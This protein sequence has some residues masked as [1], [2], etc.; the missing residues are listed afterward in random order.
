[1]VEP[2]A[3]VGGSR[4]LTWMDVILGKRKAREADWSGPSAGMHARL[5]TV[6]GLW[7]VVAAALVKPIALGPGSGS[8]EESAFQC[9]HDRAGAV[10][11]VELGE[12]A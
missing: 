1:M 8:P 7:S 2:A 12:D 5:R 6:R 11:D 4:P 3:R 10:A 9:H